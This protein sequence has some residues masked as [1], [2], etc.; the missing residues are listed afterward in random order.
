MAELNRRTLDTVYVNLYGDE[1]YHHGVLGMSWGDRNGPPYPLGGVD[2]KV[3][4]AEYKAKKEKERRVK[5]MQKAAK[6]ARKM[7]AKEAKNQSEILKK[8]QKLVKEGDLD[9]IRK[10]AELFTNEE[11]QYIIERDA[12]KRAIGSTDERTN[13]EKLELL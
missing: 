2:K 11:L 6:K 13:D 9:K 5:K 10:N 4:R 1:L 8:K 7:K 3:A 12:Q